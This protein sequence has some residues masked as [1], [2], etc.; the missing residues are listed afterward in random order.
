MLRIVERLKAKGAPLDAVGLQSHLAAGIFPFSEHPLRAFLA[1]LASLTFGSSSRSLTSPTQGYR[2]TRQSGTGSLPTSTSDI[3][4]WRSMNRLRTSSQHGGYRIATLGS[5]QI[6]RRRE[7]AD[8]PV[9]QPAVAARCG[10]AQEAGLVRHRSC[11]RQRAKALT[12]QSTL[13]IVSVS[14]LK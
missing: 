5:T 10:S 2:R 8:R 11:L 12:Y 1:E 4:R 13:G 9:V 6:P 7:K 3:W 14:L